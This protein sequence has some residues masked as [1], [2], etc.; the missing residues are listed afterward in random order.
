[1]IKLERIEV[2]ISDSRSELLMYPQ[3]SGERQIVEKEIE[4]LSDFLRLKTTE[5]VGVELV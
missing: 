3:A 4:R 1:V 5:R 2:V